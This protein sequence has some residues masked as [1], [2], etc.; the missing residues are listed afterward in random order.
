M[1]IDGLVNNG[2]ENEVYN[3]DTSGA[4]ESHVCPFCGIRGMGLCTCD[5]EKV[6]ASQSQKDAQYETGIRLEEGRA[7]L[8]RNGEQE[9]STQT[10]NESA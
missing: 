4:R 1:A 6:S 9:R 2:E 8:L 3:P 10:Q 5:L 7:R